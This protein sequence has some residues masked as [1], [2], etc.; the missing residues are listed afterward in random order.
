[1]QRRASFLRANIFEEH[2]ITFGCSQTLDVFYNGNT[3]LAPPPPAKGRS[4]VTFQDKEHVLVS[5]FCWPQTLQSLA[6]S[7]YVIH[8]PLGEG[9]IVAF[10][11]DPNFRAMYPSLQRLFLN[12]VMFGPGH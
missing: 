8:Q 11:D 10:A 7:S 4:L 6:G 12:A 1:M 2:W 9:H 5:G 3:I